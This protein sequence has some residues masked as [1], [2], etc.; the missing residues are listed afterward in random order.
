MTRDNRQAVAEWRALKGRATRAFLDPLKPLITARITRWPFTATQ[1]RNAQTC[2]RKE[3]SLLKFDSRDHRARTPFRIEGFRETRWRK[4]GLLSIIR[5]YRGALI[6]F[7]DTPARLSR[8]RQE[9][10]LR[11]RR[12]VELN[13]GDWGNFTFATCKRRCVGPLFPPRVLITEPRY[14]RGIL[15]RISLFDQ[16]SSVLN[17]REKILFNTIF[18]CCREGGVF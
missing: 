9:P 15:G 1:R 4:L 10:L 16:G 11:H 18:G 12:N 3:K 2:T 8:S 7:R 14:P 17:P 13:G 6:G 5:K